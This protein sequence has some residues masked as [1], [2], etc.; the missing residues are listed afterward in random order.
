M[1][2]S[3]Q[4]CVSES[5]QKSVVTQSGGAMRQLLSDGDYSSEFNATAATAADCN[6]RPAAAAAA[7]WRNQKF[8][9]GRA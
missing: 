1:T 9:F 8:D 4:N 7:Q 3:L 2:D 6:Q 5:W